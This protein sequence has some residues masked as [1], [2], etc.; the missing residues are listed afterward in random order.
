VERA[1]HSQISHQP[2]IARDTHHLASGETVDGYR[3]RSVDLG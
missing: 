1:S 2:E 3:A